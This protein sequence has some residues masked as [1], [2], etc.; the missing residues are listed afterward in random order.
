MSSVQIFPTD[1]P[2]HYSLAAKYGNL[3]FLAGLCSRDPKQNFTT[4]GK[5][6]E[7][8]C[9]VIFKRINDAL[10]AAGTSIENTVKVTIYLQDMADY[11]KLVEA[12]PKYFRNPPPPITIVQAKLVRA[13]EMLEVDVTAAVPGAA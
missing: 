8:Q 7:E 2:R 11:P 5:T 3:V 12:L 1:P 6:F 13:A 4:V 9:V 10:A